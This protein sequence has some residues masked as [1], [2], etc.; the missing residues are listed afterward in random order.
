MIFFEKERNEL[1][2]K[3]LEKEQRT[4]VKEEEAEEKTGGTIFLRK[5]GMNRGERQNFG[6]GGGN[7]RQLLGLGI[8]GEGKSDQQ[9]TKK[10]KKRLTPLH[11]EENY[12]PHQPPF[13][14]PQLRNSVH[15]RSNTSAAI[16]PSIANTTVILPQ[17]PAIFF[18]C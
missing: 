4:N 16:V 15:C 9:K 17:P 18:P 5:R 1:G 2:G 6:G 12:L 11:R 3:I 7:Q 8:F 14:L 10:Q 13:L